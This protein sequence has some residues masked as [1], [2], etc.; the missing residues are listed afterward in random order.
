[1]NRVTSMKNEI[2]TSMPQYLS[3]EALER[4]IA[5]TEA[6]PQLHPPK[7]FKGEVF[8]QI[9]AKKKRTKNRQMFSYS[10]KVV[11]ATAAA[12]GIVLVAPANLRNPERAERIENA[13]SEKTGEYGT[14]A[15]AGQSEGSGQMRQPQSDGSYTF[16]LNTQMDDYC[17]QFNEKLNQ[18]FGMEV[19]Y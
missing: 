18:I 7:G 3:D 8:E 17:S 11:V 10:M 12:V 15:G 2:K 9:R 1:M 13:E 16:R 5:G 14:S 19:Y 4:L 6:G